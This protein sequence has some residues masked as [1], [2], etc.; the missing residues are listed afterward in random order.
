M[1]Q[2]GHVGRK[3]G[4]VKPVF[5]VRAV[6]N[7]RFPGRKV[8]LER[9][10]LAVAGAK[11]SRGRDLMVLYLSGKSITVKQAIIANCAECMGYYDD[12]KVD[13]ENPLCACYQYMPYR[14]K[15]KE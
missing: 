2:K 15:E 9:K 5:D 11:N 1:F 6:I 4:Y 14:Q 12:K 7:N 3:V 13:C 10:A 8:D